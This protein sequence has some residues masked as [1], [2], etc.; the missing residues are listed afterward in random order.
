MKIFMLEWIIFGA[1][2]SRLTKRKYFEKKESAKDF[3]RLLRQ[4]GDMLQCYYACTITEQDLN[5]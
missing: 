3:E 5:P 1:D 2:G 4:A